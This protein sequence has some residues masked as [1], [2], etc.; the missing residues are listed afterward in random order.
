LC[1]AIGS[2]YGPA[3]ARPWTLALDRTASGL[4]AGIG[5][6]P[7]E[8]GCALVELDDVALFIDPMVP[9]DAAEFWRW[10]DRRCAGRAVAVLT[11]MNVHRGDTRVIVERYGG[12]VYA[13]SQPSVMGEEILP[14]GVE[15]FELEPVGETVVWLASARALVV[16]DALVG[17]GGGALRLCPESW[18]DVAPQTTTLS[19]LRELLRPLLALP[20]QRVLVAHGE[21]VLA[22]GHAA[23]SSALEPIAA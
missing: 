13:P 4:A 5:R 10:A 3:R 18:L 11:T 23:I 12:A 2:I 22:E 21:P 14:A 1:T 19:Q 6:K 8:V 7:R 17:A 20:I 15:C 9:A 16:G